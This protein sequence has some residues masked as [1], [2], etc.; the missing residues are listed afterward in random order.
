MCEEDTFNEIIFGLFLKNV[1]SEK[2]ALNRAFH[3]EYSKITNTTIKPGNIKE[4]WGLL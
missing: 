3:G 4:S 2:E 1:Q